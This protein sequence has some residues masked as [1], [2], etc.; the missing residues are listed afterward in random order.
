MN[1]V[2]YTVVLNDES[3]TDQKGIQ[4]LSISHADP[5]D[6]VFTLPEEEG[7]RFQAIYDSLEEESKLRTE[8]GVVSAP[9]DLTQDP[10]PTADTKR[11]ALKV[12]NI[13]IDETEGLYV[14]TC[15]G[16]LKR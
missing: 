13:D 1:I 12:C 15:S 14:F 10:P 2:V 4:V 9:A 5:A 7:K 16:R 8:L 6:I 11:Y 3:F